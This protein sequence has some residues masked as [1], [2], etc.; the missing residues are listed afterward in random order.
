MINNIVERKGGWFYYNDRKWQG[1]QSLVD[2]IREE[3]DLLEE[4]STA[5]RDV[6]RKGVVVRADDT[7]DEE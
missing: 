4:L 5:V 3:P 1:S 2:S 6:T 7:E